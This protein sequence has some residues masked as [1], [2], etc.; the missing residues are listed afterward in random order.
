ML[1]FQKARNC[2]N[3]S[4]GT[5]NTIVKQLRALQLEPAEGIKV[6]VNEENIAEVHAEVDGP[7]D[8]P[9]Q[10]GVFKLKLVLPANYPQTAPK[11]FFVTTIFH[12]NVRQPSGEI[13]VNTL[14]K[15]W[16]PTHGLRHVL[17]VI[18]CLLIEPFPESALNE[19]AAKLMLEDYDEY[20]RRAKMFT[21]IHAKVPG[22]RVQNP[23]GD[24][25]S[26][27]DMDNPALKKAKSEKKTEKKKSLRRL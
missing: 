22:A 13:C 18:R 14:Q 26:A 4:T 15:D 2:E 9:F 17:M 23:E 6:F 5:V 1:H 21:G 11:G 7:V 8:T 3:L 20:F 19:E 24:L 10:G 25:S 12:P 27:A 16:Q